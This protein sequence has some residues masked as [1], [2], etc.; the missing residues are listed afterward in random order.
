MRKYISVM[1]CLFML[2]T[3]CYAEVFDI[4]LVWDKTIIESDLD[5]FTLFVSTSPITI[6]DKP[7][8]DASWTIDI[9][10]VTWLQPF[11]ATYTYIME[12]ETSTFLYFRV[13]A[14]DNAIPPNH[15][16]CSNEVSKGFDLQSPDGCVDLEVLQ[17]TIITP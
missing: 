10:Y 13:G 12:P 11:T 15:S 6:C 4:E 8:T 7:V 5:G 3:I 14:Y 2:S 9:D 16:V 17:I 1:L